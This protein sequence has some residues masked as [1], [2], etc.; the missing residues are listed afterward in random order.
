MGFLRLI[1]N[2]IRW[3]AKRDS[4]IPG[5]SRKELAALKYI[6]APAPIPFYPPS[7]KWGTQAEP[8]KEMQAPLAPAESLK[9]LELPDGFHAELFAA[10]PDIVKVVAM[11]WD[12]RG[13]LWVSETVDYPN[14]MQPP[15][16]GND[17]IKICED[18]NNDGKADKFTIFA[19]KLSIPTSLVFANSGLIVTQAPDTL[20]FKDTNGDDKADVRTTLFTGWG[21]KDTHA[22]PSNLRYGFDNWI[23]GTVGYSGF[24]GTVGGKAMR[25][26]Q[27]I[28]RFKPDG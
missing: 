25:F 12:E 10:E 21:T 18:T 16:K 26:G 11:A 8:L 6:P 9:Y 23:W 5:A 19:D 27:G 20:Y 2:G 22:G 13:R 7:D 28:F 14:D 3:A 15:G 17:R 4:S 24:E 1:E